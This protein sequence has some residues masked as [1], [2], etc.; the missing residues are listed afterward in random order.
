MVQFCANNIENISNRVLV[1][2]SP[3]RVYNREKVL[4]ACYAFDRAFKDVG[5][6][7]DR[8]AIKVSTTG[9]A[10]AAAAQLNKEGIRTLGTSLF[11]L[12][13]AVAA[14]QAGCLYISPYF[15]EVAA[16]EDD[17]FMYKG[18]DPALEVSRPMELF[19]PQRLRELWILITLSNSIPW[20]RV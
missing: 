19:F 11:S 2:V 17:S 13:Q 4:E 6:G 15:N 1:Q 3:S 20:P 7:R 12:P 14:S 10:M 18:S 16:Y 5:I 9:P 8:Y